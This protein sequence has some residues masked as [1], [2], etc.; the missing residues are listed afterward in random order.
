MACAD[1]QETTY[2]TALASASSYA[3]SG[4]TLSIRLRDASIMTFKRAK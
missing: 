3:I 4:D 1:S 2:S